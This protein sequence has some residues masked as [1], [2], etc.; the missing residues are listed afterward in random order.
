[1]CKYAGN[2]VAA[3]LFHLKYTFVQFIDFSIEM[4]GVIDDKELIK[5]C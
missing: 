5:E 2:I 1:M 3:D 4:K